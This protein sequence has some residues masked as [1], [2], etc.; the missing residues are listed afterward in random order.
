MVVHHGRGALALQ[1][2]V[3]VVL[4]CVVG[5]ALEQAGYGGPFV[6]EAS[7]G[8]DYGVVLFGREGPVLDL[9]GEL[10]APA[11]PAG[12]AGAARDGLADEG[13]V[14]GPVLLDEPLQSLVLLRAPWAFDT[15]HVLS[16]KNNACVHKYVE[17]NRNGGGSRLLWRG[18]FASSASLYVRG[19]G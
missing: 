12:F 4:D 3:P 13:P 7:M 14:P 9:G 17:G 1:R 16:G 6:A 8:P 19:G 5:S 10:I 2:G 18:V 11:E 15:V